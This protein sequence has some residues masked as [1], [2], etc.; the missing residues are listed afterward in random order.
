MLRIS[1]LSLLMLCFSASAMSQQSSIEQN[2][3]ADLSRQILPEEVKMLGAE[4]QFLVLQRESMTAG[5]KGTV[6]LIPDATEHAASAKH[7]D[8]LRQQLNDYGWNTLAVMPP[9]TP[10]PLNTDDA[11]QRYQTALQQRMSQLQQQ[12]ML[13]AGSIVVIAQGSSAAVLN[14]LYVASELPEP[15]ALIL[16]GAYLPEDQQNRALARAIASHQIPTLDISHSHD[17]RFVKAQ[18]QLRQKLANKLLKPVYRQR[19]VTGSGS[20]TDVQQWVLQ[21]IYGWLTSVGL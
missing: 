16:L 18:L 14:R 12:A 19:L 3:T 7:I 21:E 9:D 1:Y 11:V 8:A 17:N 2:S 20:N 5:T 13:N 10:E 4:P 6:L 15:A